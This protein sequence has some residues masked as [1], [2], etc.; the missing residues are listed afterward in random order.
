MQKTL[1]AFAATVLFASQ[2]GAATV[3]GPTSVIAGQTYTYTYQPDTPVVLLEGYTLYTM[4]LEVNG[5]YEVPG[6]AS[7]NSYGTLYPAS[8]NF[9]FDWAFPAT[10][11]AILSVRSVL[12]SYI[13][14]TVN[15]FSDYF[16]VVKPENVFYEVHNSAAV[17]LRVSAIPVVPIGG[18]LPLML[19]A[20]GLMGWA[21]RRRAKQNAL[22]A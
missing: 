10:G 7:L 17:D 13:N 8:N 18:T 16:E 22:P 20:L 9:T 21:A 11:P 14:A 5:G 15:V 2:A 19:S 4:L 6:G 12:V 1:W 3:T